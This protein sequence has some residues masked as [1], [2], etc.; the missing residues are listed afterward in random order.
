MVPRNSKTMV[1]AIIWY[2]QEAK[3]GRQ[4]AGHAAFYKKKHCHPAT[5]IYC[6]S[7]DVAILGL[8]RCFILWRQKL[9]LGTLLE[10]CGVFRKEALLRG[11]I[12]IRT[13]YCS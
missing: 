10:L 1:S 13:K 7:G 6:C 5:T 4:V 11:A 9:Y 8:R 12:V 3:D 2:L